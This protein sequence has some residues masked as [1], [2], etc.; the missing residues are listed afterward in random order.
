MS[1]L[2]WVLAAGFRDGRFIAAFGR[3]LTAA[4]FLNGGIGKILA[5]TATLG[6]MASKGMPFPLLAFVVALIIEIGGG[7]LL[8]I[9][10]Q[11]RAVAFAL[12]AFCIVTAII[13]HSNFADQNMLIHFMKNLAIAG[14]LLQLVAFGAGGLSLDAKRSAN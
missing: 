7:L 8:L 1:E 10:F 11:T 4:I 9:G 6:Y 14:G 12:A 2:Q 13:F 3:L 5:P